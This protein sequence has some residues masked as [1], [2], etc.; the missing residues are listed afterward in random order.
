MKQRFPI[1]T[2]QPQHG[3]QSCPQHVV[4]GVPDEAHCNLGPCARKPDWSFMYIIL[5][6]L[7]HSM[8]YPANNTALFFQNPVNGSGEIMGN[9]V[10]AV[11]LARRHVIQSS[12]NQHSMEVFAR[13]M[14]LTEMQIRLLATQILVLV[15]KQLKT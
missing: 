15:S 2:Q 3:G 12:L 13:N 4:N 1:I 8:K 6:L 11:V 10:K 7:N 9:A 14:Y 5:H